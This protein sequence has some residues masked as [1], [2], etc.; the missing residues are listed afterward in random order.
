MRTDLSLVR[1]P[2][3]RNLPSRI[4]VR[5]G[6]PSH[7]P[8]AR[9][10]RV[11]IRTQD[12]V[13]AVRKARLPVSI[14][15]SRQSKTLGHPLSFRPVLLVGKD[16]APLLD[17]GFRTITFIDAEA[18]RSPRIEDF[19]VAMLSI[20]TLGARRIAKANAAIIDPVRL[21]K[22]ILAEGLEA[23]AY[24]V[25]LDEFAP[26]LPAPRGIRAIAKNALA[27]EDRRTFVRESRK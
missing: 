11:R 15:D 13:E 8:V 2:K 4:F 3:D 14:L 7:R 18:A 22:R 23:R 9:Y 27:S 6:R 12:D 21:L 17:T 19:I 24:R 26:G 20:D 5:A 1:D 16:L 10:S 25:R